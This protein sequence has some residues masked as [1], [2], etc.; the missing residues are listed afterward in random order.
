MKNTVLALMVLV[1]IVSCKSVSQ[2]ENDLVVVDIFVNEIENDRVKVS[3]N[4]GPVASDSLKFY[5]PK[6]VPG[7]YEINNYGQFASELIA[8][9][10]DGN[11][12]ETIRQDDNTWVISNSSDFDKLIYEVD[13]TYD[14]EGE[15]GVFSPAGTNFEAGDNFMLNLHAMVGYFEDAKEIPYKINI[16]RPSSLA[17][18]ASLPVINQTDK[19][20]YVIDEFSTDRYF[21]VIDHPILYSE[22]DTTSFDIE[23]MKVL[24]SVHSP[25]KIHT[26]EDL[27]PALE[28]MVQAQKSFL[29][30]IDNTNI[31]AILLYLSEMDSPDARGFGALE[32]HTSTSVVLPETMSLEQLEE[33]MTDVVSH[34][35]F[36]II[37]PLNIHSKEVHYF[38]YNDPEMS[39]HL[40]MYEGVTEYFANL[41]QI[42]Q[43]LISE[44]EFYQR[45]N[46]KIETSMAFDD[47]MAFTVMSENILEDEYKDSYYNVYQKGALIGMAL[48]IRLREL[49]DGQMGIL[50]LMK[51]LV[52]KY[53]KD[54]PFED[55]ALIS[56]IV[57]M[58]YP[59][60]QS[61]FDSYVTGNTPIPYDEFFAKVGVEKTESLSK[62]GYFLNGRTPYIDVNQDEKTIFFRESYPMNS[63]FKDLGVKGG[64]VIK[65][66]NGTEYTLQN[67]RDLISTSMAW[68][69]GQDFTMTVI[70]DGEE[71]TFEGKTAQPYIKK[72]SLQSVDLDSDAPEFKLRQAWLKD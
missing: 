63:F 61:F 50:D 69:E 11:V 34:E 9:D 16:H 29:G 56:E 46:E 22:P 52:S 53:G 51:K 49:S 48:D 68:Q 60:I 42:N 18:S 67:I 35:F 32:H 21:G 3:M 71:M 36:H 33:T 20:T 47:T 59:E 72:T 54:K 12:M 57:A 62:T 41:F 14:I 64:D 6:T 24:L 5:L 25:N 40:W 13:D 39:K 31:Y 8:F 58:T 37:T 70:R 65:S 55:E 17:A 7:T 44:E 26:T 30:E 45:M 4:P 1:G 10:Y 28:K 43:G 2:K 15:G 27:K 19:G 38:D 23:G 66:I